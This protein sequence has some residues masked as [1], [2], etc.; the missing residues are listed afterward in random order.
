M[1]P[2]D[3]EYDEEY[4]K[5]LKPEVQGWAGTFYRHPLA[6]AV[7]AVPPESPDYHNYLPLQVV[8]ALTLERS[9]MED[10]CAA[11]TLLAQFEKPWEVGMEEILLVSPDLEWREFQLRRAQRRLLI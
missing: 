2:S 7:R 5:S 1:V 11:Q 10:L 9:V 6:F 8:S 4:V 3:E